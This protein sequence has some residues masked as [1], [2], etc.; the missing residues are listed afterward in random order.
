MTNPKPAANPEDDPLDIA[1]RHLWYPRIPYAMYS[2]RERGPIQLIRGEG[3]FVW[4]DHGRRYYDGTA[5]LC[6]VNVGHGRPELR[7][8]ALDQMEALAFHNPCAAVNAPTAELARRLAALAPDDL[9]RVFFTPSGSTA[10][11]VALRIARQFHYNRGER[12]RYK[13][14][15][16]YGSYHGMT[17]GVLAVNVSLRRDRVPGEPAGVGALPVAGL[18]CFRCHYERTYPEC[19]VFC[20]RIIED[21][22]TAE[23]PDTVAAVLAEPLDTSYRGQSPPAEY[24][25]TI[26]EICDRH[27]ILLIADEVVTGLGRTGRWFASETFGVR[28]DLIAVAKGL[29]SGH[30]AAGATIAS[31]R[32]FAAF[33]GMGDQL[34]IISSFAGQPVASRVALANLDILERDGLVDNARALGE[35]LAEELGAL[36]QR[37][38]L[39]GNVQGAG[40]LWSI[41]LVHAAE[42]RYFAGPEIPTLAGM[43]DAHLRRNEVLMLASDRIIFAPPLCI[44][45]DEL[46]DLLGR[47]EAALVATQAELDQGADQGAAGR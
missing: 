13:V 26:R 43:L 44:T 34:G 45:K 5:G 27:G 28:P 9:D 7:Q 2:D 39:V 35:L 6:V 46:L 3:I 30:V 42:D 24:W 18:D 11:E 25:P 16:R 32:V 21:I 29:T 14:V 38:P 20:A 8:A 1:A 22:V 19:R 23:G 41:Q 10:V 31:S 40:L 33:E 37:M 4:D 17:G 47:V 36:R 15:T 12:R